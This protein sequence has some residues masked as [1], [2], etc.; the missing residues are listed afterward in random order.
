MSLRKDLTLSL[1]NG[2]PLCDLVLIDTVNPLVLELRC[3]IFGPTGIASALARLTLTP[4]WG[5]YK[6]PIPFREDWPF[7]VL[8]PLL[9]ETN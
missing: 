8:K 5:K 6:G 3:T 9:I 2:A 1:R 4:A 7:A